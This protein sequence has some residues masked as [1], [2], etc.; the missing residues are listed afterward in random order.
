MELEAGAF[1]TRFASEVRAEMARQRKN[2]RGLA[3]AIN[4]T[5][6]TA[7]KRLSGK[8]AF[9]AIEMY[10]TAAW[11]GLPLSELVARASH[12]PQSMK[13]AA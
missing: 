5:E 7:G 8:V 1:M 2:A 13:A 6:A 9:N 3:D 12:S 4:V 10:L 11:L